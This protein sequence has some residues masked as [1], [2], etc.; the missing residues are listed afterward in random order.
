M[1][2]H[3]IH[4]AKGKCGKWERKKWKRI[5]TF[6]ILWLFTLTSFYR[7]YQSVEMLFGVE[8]F[9]KK[10]I[11]LPDITPGETMS[12]HREGRNR[13]TC[14]PARVCIVTA[15][16]LSATLAF[17]LVLDYF[18]SPWPTVKLPNI[19]AYQKTG[20][21]VQI[22]WFRLILFNQ[23]PRQL[24]KSIKS[25]LKWDENLLMLWEEIFHVENIFLYGKTI[26]NI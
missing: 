8:L 3:W 13:F 16:P 21:N 18:P 10:K 23:N 9:A 6:L 2:I 25:N 15:Y 5:F 17:R 4:T 1:V 11:S 7:R 14:C 19:S 24:C 26:L 20:S 12:R 22:L